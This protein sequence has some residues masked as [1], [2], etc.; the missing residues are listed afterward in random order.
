MKFNRKTF[1]EQFEKMPI[2][3]EMR[4]QDKR[5]KFG[6]YLTVLKEWWD[7]TKEQDEGFEAELREIVEN[8]AKHGC[9]QPTIRI[10]EILG[11]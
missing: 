5:L 6:Q 11:E 3:G 2:Y 7:K 9:M 4:E 1:R 10:K 8:E